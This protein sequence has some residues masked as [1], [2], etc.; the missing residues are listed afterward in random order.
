[1]TSA[2]KSLREGCTLAQEALGGKG[3]E[4]TPSPLFLLLVPALATIRAARVWESPTARSVYLAPPG[5]SA[6]S[7]RRGEVGWHRQMPS[8]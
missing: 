6:A 2:R 5:R 7:L 1:M 4:K 8:G 3:G